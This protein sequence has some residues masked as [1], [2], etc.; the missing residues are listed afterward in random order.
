MRVKM[1]DVLGMETKIGTGYVRLN[2]QI[3]QN[4]GSAP[5][6]PSVSLESESTVIVRAKLFQPTWVLTLNHFTE[7]RLWRR[8]TFYFGGG[9]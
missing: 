7:K 2:W 9:G 6:M 3:F 4:V 5:S 1:A 8:N